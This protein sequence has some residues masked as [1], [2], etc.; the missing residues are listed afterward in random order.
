MPKA[1]E[2]MTLMTEAADRFNM[3]RDG[4]DRGFNGLTFP[5]VDFA[6]KNDLAWLKE[7][8][9]LTTSGQRR[10]VVEAKQ[11]VELKA[12]HLGIRA[13]SA[14]EM[15]M[16]LECCMPDIKPPYVIDQ[17]FLLAITRPGLSLPLFAAHLT[18]ECWKDP[19]DFGA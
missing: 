5:M 9:T 13:R 17:P 14:D 7:L 1:P 18:P 6:A 8:W 12:S 2:G 3:E 16:S 4:G 15:R 19:G 10:K 11:Q